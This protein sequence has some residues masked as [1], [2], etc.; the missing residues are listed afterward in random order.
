MPRGTSKPVRQCVVERTGE[1][2][3][4]ER[5]SRGDGRGK[6]RLLK[7]RRELSV[8]EILKEGMMRGS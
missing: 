2:E 6:Y 4:D 3:F 7:L 1:Q 8:V 5:L